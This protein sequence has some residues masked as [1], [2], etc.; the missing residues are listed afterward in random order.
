MGR[1]NAR[2]TSTVNIR[3]QNSK[4]NQKSHHCGSFWSKE[5]LSIYYATSDLFWT[6]LTFDLTLLN[7]DLKIHALAFRFKCWQK[8]SVL[9]TP[10]MVPMIKT[11]Q[12][13]LS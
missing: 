9:W 5:V 12:N 1:K 7:Q 10:Q 2:K 13:A 3:F 4:G 6:P 8:K 11:T